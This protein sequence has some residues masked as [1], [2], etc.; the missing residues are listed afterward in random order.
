ML[1]FAR[2]LF[3]PLDL[4]QRRIKNMNKLRTK[5]TIKIYHLDNN[6]EGTFTSH[7]YKVYKS[8]LHHDQYTYN[9]QMI[10]NDMNTSWKY[11]YSIEYKHPINGKTLFIKAWV[12]VPYTFINRLKEEDSKSYYNILNSLEYYLENYLKNRCLYIKKYH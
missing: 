7:G 1:K 12:Y 8:N 10:C 6:Y 4:K 5:K 9:N 11:S 2:V 3:S